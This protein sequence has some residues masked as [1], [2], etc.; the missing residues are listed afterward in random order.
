[1]P[2]T[3]IYNALGLIQNPIHIIESLFRDEIFTERNLVA[4]SSGIYITDA[5]HIYCNSL[6]GSTNNYYDGAYIINYTVEGGVGNMAKVISYDAA[7]KYITLYAITGQTVGNNFI[8][9]NIG[10]DTYINESNFDTVGA[11]FVDYPFRKSITEKAKV[12]DILNE[13]LFE[14]HCYLGQSFNQLKIHSLIT[15]TSTANLI[16]A[17]NILMRDG[18]PDIECRLT[19][20]D[21]VKNNF[22][23]NYDYDYTTNQHKKNIHRDTLTDYRCADATRNYL[24]HNN[25]FNYDANWTYTLTGLMTWF[26][27][28]LTF[29]KLE[30]K[31]WSDFSL[32][33]YEIGDQ[34]KINDSRWMPTNLNNS[35]VFIV[36]GKEINFASFGVKLTLLQMP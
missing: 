6:R 23:L 32:F 20:I 28:W 8:I 17:S 25:E 22:L 4:S 10:G 34:C 24:L 18:S 26:V 13:L 7:N 19:D 31:L 36:M 27:K 30:I 35:A 11:S 33:K 29:Q 21:K 9:T 1:M 15:D 16:T 14:C 12:S 2:R 5:T 3:N